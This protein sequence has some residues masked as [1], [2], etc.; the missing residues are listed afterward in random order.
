MKLRPSLF[1]L[2]IFYTTNFIFAQ[3]SSCP[4]SDFETGTM[5]N[6]S[7]GVGG[8]CPIYIS[9]TAIVNGR[10][11]IMSGTGT[12]INTCGNVTVVAP[13]GLYSAR[14]GNDI[15][16]AQAEKLSYTLNVTANNSLFIY[17]YA[18]V[19]EDPGHSPS[20]QPRFQISVKNSAGN[21][22]DPVCGEYTVVSGSNIPG[23]QTCNGSVRYK[24]WTTVGL[25]L[26][27]YIGQNI[28]IEFATG[29]CSIGGHYGYAY[30]DA[31]C[32]PLQISSTYCTGSFAAV[33]S[34]PI[35]FTYLWNTGETTQSINVNN[36][37]AGL[38]YTCLLTSVTGCTVN[39][40][41][42]LTLFDPVA[43]FNITNT[44]YDNAIFSN[45]TYLPTGTILDTFVWNFGDGTTSNIENPTH[46]Y[47]NPG[48]YNVTFT[49]SNALGCTSTTSHTVTVYQSPTAAINYSGAD[50]CS[51][52][53]TPQSVNLSGT[54][55]Y[56]GGVYSS[57]TGLT[58]DPNSGSIT[59]S[60]S[61]PGT[62]TVS[63][64][65]PTANGCSVP[66]STTSVTI[67]QSPTAI[68][69][70]PY[71]PYCGNIVYS[72]AC[73]LS[74]TGV[75]SGG[76]FSSTPGLYINATTGA[77]IPSQSN[78]GTYV[79][80][81]KMPNSG[82]CT[83]GSVTTTISINDFP[84]ALISYPGSPFC[85]SLNSDQ[86]VNFSGTYT[87]T[88]GVFSAPSG[89]FINSITGAVNP[90]LSTPGTYLV[91]YTIPSIVN[92]TLTPATTWVTITH[93]PSAVI[94]YNSP[95]CNDV[96]LPQ[97]VT[98]TGTAAYLNGTF[99]STSGLTINSISGS[100]I[101]STSIPANYTVTYTIPAHAG[102]PAIPVNA[103]LVVYPLPQPTLSDG[104]ICFD[105]TGAL[106]RSYTLI[107]GLS[108]A[109]FSFKWFLNGTII[110]TATQSYYVATAIGNY[111][112][113]ATNLLTGC[114]SSKVFA[115]IISAQMAT[116]FVTSIDDE[117]TDNNI[118]SVIVQG[119]TG[120]FYYQLDN[121]GFQS[122]NVFHSVSSGN[123]LVS[124]TDDTNCTVIS[125]NIIVMGYPKFFTP[126][127]DGNNDFW[128]IYHYKN[129]AD[130]KIYIF[131]RFGKILKVFSPTSSG[132]DGTYNGEM[133]PSTDYWFIVK[134]KDYNTSG[135]IE[136]K[137]YKS[138]FAMKR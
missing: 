51:S 117:F 85:D 104:D 57:S 113:E 33:L 131:D 72:Q 109:Q 87:Y 129:I 43:D 16:G 63:Y 96:N 14:L 48:T 76:T 42:N 137:E 36:P 22:I 73:W 98:L 47:T 45:T 59:P 12:D 126:N 95:F 30:V 13:G 35:G 78:S 97:M 56:T 115:T 74:G 21:L 118:L 9:G 83:G 31:Y 4:N 66:A 28:T 127:G 138:H 136:Y 39:I 108:A 89:L 80:T 112:V 92:C 100:V 52:A 55:S 64:T 111:S 133:M 79:V 68:I 99:T 110:P 84:T 116:D 123:H 121:S 10:H 94:S 86:P 69:N 125:K 62:Y 77:I 37:N 1:L 71:S 114:K 135:Q 32:S 5:A 11:T 105:A 17:K 93:L 27:S 107:S 122:S 6:W 132:W 134:Y 46:T 15:S 24:D 8:C 124:I 7:G 49:I 19:L 75:Y 26:S 40:S 128:N 50:F 103:P 41:T 20:E 23:F 25:D 88:G 34:A 38:T 67:T 44:C 81:Y 106:A 119:G 101:P 82:G 53:T 29:D 60:L 90:S 58:I 102:C 130:A 54:N 91:S 2:L 70:Y 65:I 3:Q 61:T 18:V 120:P